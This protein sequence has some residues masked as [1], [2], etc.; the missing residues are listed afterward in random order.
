MPMS[1]DENRRPV[2]IFAPDG[3]TNAHVGPNDVFGM[4]VVVF[5]KDVNYSIVDGGATFPLVKGTPLGVYNLPTIWLDVD[6]T[7]AF[8][9]GSND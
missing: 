3:I 6:G 1:L 9:R 5:N 8:M 4:A 2:Q 7:M